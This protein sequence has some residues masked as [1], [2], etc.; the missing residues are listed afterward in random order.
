MMSSSAETFAINT[1]SKAFQKSNAEQISYANVAAAH[2]NA[3]LIVRCC[4]Q[5]VQ[6]FHDVLVN[7]FL[8]Q[9]TQ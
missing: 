1:L 2:V 8:K 3:L 4:V 5:I 9:R 6:A 7:V